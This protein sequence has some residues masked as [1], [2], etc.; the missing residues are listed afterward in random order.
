MNDTKL[1]VNLDNIPEGMIMFDNWVCWKLETRTDGTPTKVPYIF[2]DNQLIR[3]DEEHYNDLMAF[4]DAVAIAEEYELNGIG[5]AFI[6][7]GIC[8]I[9]VDHCV[10]DGKLTDE[11]AKII[12]QFKDTYCEYSPSGTG[13]HIY[14]HDND[15]TDFRSRRKSGYEIYNEKHYFTVTGNTI[16]GTGNTIHT[17]NGG[18]KKFVAEYIGINND[19]DTLDE[20]QRK[21]IIKAHT[22][23][24]NHSDDELLNIINQSKNA[25]KF[26][27][28][29]KDGN[30][31][32]YGNDDSAADMALMCHLAYW[33][34][35]NAIQM[36][37]IFSKSA[38]AKRSKWSREDYRQRTI[39]NAI[40]TQENQAPLNNNDAK[41]EV[42]EAIG[43]LNS[44]TDYTPADVFKA[45]I[46]RAAATCR[47]NPNTT[48]IYENFRNECKKNKD[49]SMK[50]LNENI[51]TYYRELKKAKFKVI[52][53]SQNI[54]KENEGNTLD[55]PQ[56]PDNSNLKIE[57]FII[58]QNFNI[59][60]GG[61]YSIDEKGNSNKFCNSTIFVIKEIVNIDEHIYKTQLAC[62]KNGKRWILPKAFDNSVIA[63]AQ[64]IVLLSDYGID[65]NSN[66]AKTMIRY[67]DAFRAT[68]CDI[69]PQVES[70]NKC[71]WRDE[72]T[73]ITP[74]NQ[75]DY[76]VDTSKNSFA[77][78]ALTQKGDFN[79]WL[80]TFKEIRE[81][82]LA[83]F[84]N[85][86]ALATPL[87]Y[88]LDER[89]FSIYTTAD[90]KAGKT[91]TM[92]FG[93]SAWGNP[94]E[95]A[96]N[97]NCTINGLEVSAA[98]RS[99]FP[100]IIN[101][102]QL[103]ESQNKRN[104]LDMTKLLYLLGEGEGKSRMDRNA[105]ERKSYKWR[106][107]TLAN[108]ETDIISDET[109][110]GAITRTLIFN[111]PDKVLPDELSRKAYRVMK[112]NYGH[113]GQIFIDNLLKEN[114]EELR[115]QYETITNLLR[116]KFNKHIDDHIRYVGVISL[117][118]FMLNKYFFKIN[119]KTAFEE[120][121]N[122]AQQILKMLKTQDELSDVKNEWNFLM[123][124]IVENTVNFV[125]TDEND[126]AINA[127]TYGDFSDSEYRYIV[128][129]PFKEAAEKAG[130]N[131]P[132]MIKDFAKAGYTI[133][134][135]DG[136]HTVKR[137]I[138]G[139][140]PRC[141]KIPKEKAGTK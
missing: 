50:T 90:S 62:C 16:E 66:N 26:N 129:Q 8:G 41:N 43:I 115:G 133:T 128:A 132:K 64:K 65:V 94:D 89:S 17:Y 21:E 7:D 103:A 77:A 2:V 38:L 124:W 95:I 114:F 118:D 125:G 67:L 53:N 106:T 33:T 47:L 72:K 44:I 104:R 58:P 101:E 13:I 30:I 57:N 111:V 74:Y 126:K 1:N 123:S 55:L 24:P 141:L 39:A 100:L 46:Y 52:H 85:D 131:Y 140:S 109:T 14:F 78:N 51:E 87:L 68:N 6:G 4:S 18:A 63:S 93:G 122:L 37:S 108:G 88:I 82:T 61:M 134:N 127:K 113:A 35:C 120:A 92:K 60:N 110:Q 28:L 31:S 11:V 98:L 81:H 99:D 20:T 25:D 130:Y 91:A 102:K 86:A 27:A 116:E 54:P 121:I 79:V 80:D 19:N 83:R 40:K 137:R 32:E 56:L 75:S 119:E 107:I 29:F 5:F 15:L 139:E 23:K 96:K 117:C 49:I 10:I 59:Y 12:E 135:N 84:I 138:K 48:L 22:F 97:F 136:R 71:G 69:I 42:E 73:F 34:N 3:R 70:V 105:N 36:E 112:R 9:D 45:E 76:V